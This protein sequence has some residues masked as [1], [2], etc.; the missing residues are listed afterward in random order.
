MMQRQRT[1]VGGVP[2]WVLVVD[3]DPG[4]RRAIA[5][6]LTDEG[7]DV[8]T[9]ADGSAALTRLHDIHPQLILL[10]LHLPD[11]DGI[12]VINHLAA[13]GSAVPVLTMSASPLPD[14]L[15]QHTPVVGHVVK[16]FDIDEF[17]RVVASVM[18][19]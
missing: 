10:D 16:P 7:Y 9:A 12:G 17:L 4:T 6:L 8:A 5:A 3:D 11:M 15:P 13:R 18:D 2:R 14:S 19:A 1:V